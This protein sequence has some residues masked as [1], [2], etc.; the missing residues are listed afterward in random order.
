TSNHKSYIVQKSNIAMA[1]DQ[2]FEKDDHR[3]LDFL[4]SFFGIRLIQLRQLRGLK[5]REKAGITRKKTV[6][7]P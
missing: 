3:G 4:L 7:R 2:F 6:H 5:A 1:L